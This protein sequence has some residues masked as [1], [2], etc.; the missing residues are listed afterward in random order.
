LV[1]FLGPASFVFPIPKPRQR[2]LLRHFVLVIIFINLFQK[3]A[4]PGFDGS[5][6]ICA[7]ALTS[8]ILYC[9]GWKNC[10][11]RRNEAVRECAVLA[12]GHPRRLPSVFEWYYF[13]LPVHEM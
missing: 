13:T 8:T 10:Q 1:A 5:A 12:I 3:Y 9:S 4:A 11:M 2:H 7:H 6:P